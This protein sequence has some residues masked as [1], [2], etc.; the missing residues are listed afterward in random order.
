MVELAYPNIEFRSSIDAKG[1]DFDNLGHG[2]HSTEGLRF[3]M[4]FDP[5]GTPAVVKIKNVNDNGLRNDVV[6]D[7]ARLYPKSIW[8]NDGSF[9]FT[10]K[11]RDNIFKTLAPFLIGSGTLL[12]NYGL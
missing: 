1:A 3:L 4:N 8:G 5:T 10:G 9:S 7:G 6:I 12:I 11:N 2:I